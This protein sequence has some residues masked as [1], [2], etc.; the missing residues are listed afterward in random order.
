[1]L[2]LSGLYMFALPY[3]G[4]W[5]GGRKEEKRTSASA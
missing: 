3:A 1:L 5:R 2:L 4:S